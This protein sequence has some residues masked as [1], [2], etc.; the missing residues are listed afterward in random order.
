M[1]KLKQFFW[2]CSGADRTILQKCKTEGTKY[3]G[4]GATIFFT[5]IFAFLAASYAL[6]TVFNNY[7]VSIP[8]GLVWGFM[9]F[10]L[11]RYIV[12]SMRKEGSTWREWKTALP[13]LV[14]AILI[15]I[16]IAKPLELKI[17]EKEINAELKI[18]EQ[19]TINAQENEVKLRFDP[20]RERLTNEITSLRNEEAIKTTKRDELNRIAREE[21]DGTGGTKKKNAGPIYKI[22]KAEAEQANKELEELKMKN[23]KLISSKLKSIAQSDSTKTSTLATLVHQQLD[24]PAARMEALNRLTINSDAIWWANWLVILLF[25]AVETAPVFVKLI[26][27]SGPYDQLLKAEENGIDVSHLEIIAQAHANAKN[28]NQNLSDTELQYLNDQ[29]DIRLNRS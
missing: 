22:K 18:M 8:A 29:L 6:F 7:W 3:V 17:F 26:S 24:G 9:I 15:S 14:L 28:R 1:E 12:S 21:A 16:I 10:N 27:P 19:Q 25:I 20:E 13:R 2:V 5:G 4:I 11:D 23:G